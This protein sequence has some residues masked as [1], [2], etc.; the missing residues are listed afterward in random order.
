M[1]TI[2]VTGGCGFIGSNFILYWS[3]T[4]PDWQIVNL[5]SM[6]YAAHPDN[7]TE[8]ENN[9]NY[10]FLKDDINHVTMVKKTLVHYQPDVIVHFAAESHVDRSIES[11]GLFVKTNVL[12]TVNFLDSVRFYM[13]RTTKKFRF[14]HVSTDEVYGS[15]NADDLP[16]TELNQYAP[17]SP[18]SASKAASDHF[19]RAYHRTHNVPAIIS[20]CSNNYG[21]R[22]NREKFI[23]TVIRHALA[24]QPIPVYGSGMNVR[25]W[26]WVEDHC[27]A[28]DTLIQHGKFGETYCIGGGEELANIDL[29]KKILAL[30]NKP[31]SLISFVTDRAGHD[32][33]YAIDSSKIGKLGWQPQTSFDQGLQATI[34]WYLQ[35]SE[36]LQ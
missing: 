12:G 23:P 25:D 7:L 32:F 8:L 30:M 17:N 26:L 16:F 20:N 15:L 34:D 18:Y 11:S 24:N 35:H 19:V 6:T 31:E 3:H 5:D 4:Y 1:K 36:R 10:V 27:R 33:R 28:L 22:Q 13:P 29:A 21:P 2:F 14:L 9:E